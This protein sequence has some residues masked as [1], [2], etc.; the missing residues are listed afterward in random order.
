MKMSYAVKISIIFKA[1]NLQNRTVIYV[2]IDLAFL[3]IVLTKMAI[4]KWSLSVNLLS[5]N[6]NQTEN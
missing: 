6:I 4:F 5:T 3:S 1:E 2:V